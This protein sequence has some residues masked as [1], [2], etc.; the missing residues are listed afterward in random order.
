MTE[1][2]T[3]QS[4]VVSSIVLVQKD[5]GSKMLAEGREKLLRPGIWKGCKN[6]I[7]KCW[8]AGEG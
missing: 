8:P 6:W 4:S 1:S 7:C 2:S 5:N 3:S